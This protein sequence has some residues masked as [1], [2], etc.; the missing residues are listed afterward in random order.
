MFIDFSKA[1]DVVNRPVLFYEIMKCCWY[2]I[3]TDT[4]YESV[5]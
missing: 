4:P 3:V 5:H 1:F 2:R